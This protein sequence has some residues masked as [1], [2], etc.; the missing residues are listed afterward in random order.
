MGIVFKNCTDVLRVIRSWGRPQVS[1]SYDLLLKSKTG[2]SVSRHSPNVKNNFFHASPPF[3]FN[4][5]EQKSMPKMAIFYK[6]KLHICHI[7]VKMIVFLFGSHVK[8]FFKGEELKNPI[9]ELELSPPTYLSQQKELKHAKQLII[10]LK[11]VNLLNPY[12]NLNS[13]LI[14]TFQT[15]SLF[16][17]SS[18]CG[19]HF[20]YF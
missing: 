1:V 17:L 9:S 6:K 7:W 15:N 11:Q 19:K 20:W 2:R 5:L 12:F 4:S 16:S 14:P 10:Q 3:F 13:Q 8:K 18:T